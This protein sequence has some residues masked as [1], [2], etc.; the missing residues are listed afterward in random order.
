MTGKQAKVEERFWS[1]VDTSGECWQWTAALT[2]GYGRFGIG[3]KVV[4]AHRFAWELA[5]GPIPDGLGVLH[6]CDNPSCVR[7]AHLFVGTSK[8]NMQDCASKG[9]LGA[10]R[11]PAFYASFP[12]RIPV[13]RR[14]RGER[15]HSAKLNASQVTEIRSLANTLSR[16]R[17]AAKFGVTK[18]AINAVVSRTTW[19][20]VA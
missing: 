10:Q 6:A 7:P 1:K 17:I 13:D 3:R 9:R 4:L 8:D 12:S 15:Q 16:S 5:N 14:A 19:R 2:N 11:Y 20:H 18:Q